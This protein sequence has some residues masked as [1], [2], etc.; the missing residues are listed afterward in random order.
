[1][2]YYLPVLIFK[3]DPLINKHW[4]TNEEIIIRITD[5]P[6]RCAHSYVVKISLVA[7]TYGHYNPYLDFDQHKMHI[8]QDSQKKDLD[9][10]ALL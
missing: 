4:L 1:M 7:L 3:I 10:L 9:K 2:E 5:Y 8:E 6:N